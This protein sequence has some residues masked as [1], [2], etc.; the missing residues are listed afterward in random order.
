VGLQELLFRFARR[1]GDHVHADA[2]M[3]HALLDARH[4]IGIECRVVAAAHAR[5][6]R[7]AAALQ[8][9]VEVRA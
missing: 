1:A 8:G 5:Q 9:H 2:G 6:D 4:A 7:V 3:G